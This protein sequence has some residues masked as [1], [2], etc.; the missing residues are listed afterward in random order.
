MKTE[1]TDHARQNAN[2]WAETIDEYIAALDMDWDRYDELKESEE[3]TKEEAEELE[4]LK[5]IAGEFESQE[6][7]LE[8]IYE[9]PLEISVRTSWH[10]PGSD[11]KPD[12]FMILL[13]T[14]GPALRIVGDL[15]E[16]GQPSR[17]RLQY[18]GWGTP[19][20]ETFDVDIDN[21]QRFCKCFYFG[22]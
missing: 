1:E 22:D 12:E 13:S 11:E 4:E 3:L 17:P 7:V 9:S 2:G 5:G 6:D 8:R 20:T 18:Q 21:L 16:H 15:D 14:G 10:L 19:W